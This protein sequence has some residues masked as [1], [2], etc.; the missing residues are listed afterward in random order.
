M[1]NI[2]KG[3]N[4]PWITTEPKFQGNKEEFMES[5]KC[6]LGI[7]LKDEPRTIELNYDSNLRTNYVERYYIICA[8]RT[9]VELPDYLTCCP[10]FKPYLNENNLMLLLINESPEYF[11]PEKLAVFKESIELK[12][13]EQKLKGMK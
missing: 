4:A 8:T 5:L 1:F 6:Y 2:P 3:V 13:L 9:W 12:V 11:N 10:M 7:I